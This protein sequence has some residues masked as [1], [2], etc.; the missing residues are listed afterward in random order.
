[1][2]ARPSVI[3]GAKGSVARACLLGLFAT[4]ALVAMPHR[5]EAQSQTN[6][7]LYGVPG[8]IDMPSAGGA[9]R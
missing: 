3:R 4:G 5:A 1:M 7:N 6:Y 2:P 8:L 9:R